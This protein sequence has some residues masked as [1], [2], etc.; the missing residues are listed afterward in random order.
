MNNVA[1]NMVEATR[2][3]KRI[4]H[5]YRIFRLAFFPVGIIKISLI[6]KSVL[7]HF[8]SINQQKQSNLNDGELI[9]PAL[10]I[11]P[12]AT[13]VT[14]DVFI[15]QKMGVNELTDGSSRIFCDGHFFPVSIHGVAASDYGQPIYR[16]TPVDSANGISTST[17][18]ATQA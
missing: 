5:F 2:Q 1:H 3:L 16:L 13:P 10:I 9:M 6:V 17:Q 11:A 8:Q 14:P 15:L 18:I 12:E 7:M 4:T